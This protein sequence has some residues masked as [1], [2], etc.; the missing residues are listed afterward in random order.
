MADLI[1]SRRSADDLS[2]IYS[3]V[4][5]ESDRAASN[6]IDS[7]TMATV[8]LSDFPLSG[9]VV[10]E[11]NRQD[12]RE[13]IVGNYRVVYQLL[14]ESVGIALVHHGAR[15]LRRSDLRQA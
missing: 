10:P 4:S 11:F 8:R 1:W 7:I 3:H 14:G 6:L 15:L 9:R 13:V 5:E 2:A 12:I